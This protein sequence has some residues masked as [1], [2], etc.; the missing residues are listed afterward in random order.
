MESVRCC[1]GAESGEGWG[2]S[3]VEGEV[4]RV[5]FGEGGSDWEGRGG[6]RGWHAYYQVEK[7][8]IICYF[9]GI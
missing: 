5:K 3:S 6:R 2:S 4:F 9:I 8:K 1:G 7:S